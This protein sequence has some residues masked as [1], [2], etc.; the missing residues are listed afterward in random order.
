MDAD[1]QRRLDEAAAAKAE[2]EAAQAHAAAAKAE[3]EAAQA[4][5][6]VTKAEAEAAQAEAAAAK[7][8]TDARHAEQD[9]D[10]PAAV[11]E[12]DAL[13]GKNAAE[14]DAAAAAA[15]REQLTAL[16]PD[17][18]KVEA[19]TLDVK[20]GPPLWSTYLLG[21]ALGAAAEE[22]AKSVQTKDGPVRRI[23]VTSD[24]DLASSDTV[25]M[26]VKTGL[27]ELF[28]AADTLLKAVDAPMDARGLEPVGSALDAVSAV[29]TAVPAV[30]SLFSAKRTLSTGEV[31]PTDL[32]ASAAVAGEM[33]QA[34]ANDTI[35]HD[36]F[37]LVPPD[38]AISILVEEVAAG[39]Q[40]LV[41]WKITL[42]DR[43]AGLQ[44]QRV[45]V[46]AELD[47]LKKATAPDQT[48]IDAKSEELAGLQRQLSSI[49]ARLG[50]IE[51][52]LA[53]IDGYLTTIRTPAGGQR[54]PLATASLHAQLH[55]EGAT[56]FTHV[57]LVKAQAG[58][59]QQELENRPL[60]W[61]DKF[62][63]AVDVSLTHMLI[64]T[65]ASGIEAAGSK[66]VS[67][68]AHGKIGD[69]PTI[70]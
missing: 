25:Y 2:A 13:A 69:R 42:G 68:T 46:Q 44:E 45:A 6:A 20:D 33:K 24:P 28:G 35:V 17:F 55:A 18:S 1:L 15:R 67:R 47:Q 66:T 64:E 27:K 21:H 5:A 54:S 53:A 10:A 16:M 61:R 8:A 39:R 70:D 9:H 19:S 30:L 31:T 32:A 43:K 63:V 62:S 52:L 29:A 38:N 65:K 49:D 51:S 14:A 40:E 50:M 12:R 60:W 7:T 4:R 57:L 3:A 48:K 37:R 56:G 59:A 41:A 22:V 23:L 26:D 36:N 11:R 58:Q 34:N